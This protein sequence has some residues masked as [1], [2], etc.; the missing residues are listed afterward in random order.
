M[1]IGKGQHIMWKHYALAVAIQGVLICHAA[2]HMSAVVK[3]G[4]ETI[5]GTG[6]VVGHAG[7]TGA[8]VRYEV[9][10]PP[11][12]GA[13]TVNVTGTGDSVR[14]Y[15]ISY[16]SKPGFVGSDGFS[17][18]RIARDGSTKNFSFSIIVR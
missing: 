8:D 5:I 17:I 18:Q 14:I 2:A 1:V 9:A 12:N 13:A 10:Q 16:K 6:P 15:H 3:S 11:S 7:S 4:V